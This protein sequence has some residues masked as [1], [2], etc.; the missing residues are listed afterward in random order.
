MLK[1]QFYQFVLRIDVSQCAALGQLTAG[2]VAV[3]H[4]RRALK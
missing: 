1:A 4:L 3:Q 2:L